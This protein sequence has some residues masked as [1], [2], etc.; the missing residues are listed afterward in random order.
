MGAKRAAST[1]MIQKIHNEYSDVLSG[2]RGFKGTFLLQVKDDA[3][4]Y[5]A[6]PRCIVY[7]LQEPFKEEIERLQEHQILAQLRVGKMAK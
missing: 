5:Q 1:E 4:P 7:V 3:K 2:I 6:S